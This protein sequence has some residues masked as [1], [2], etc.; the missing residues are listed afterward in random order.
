MPVTS[1]GA[2]TILLAEDDLAVRQLA[3][4]I[5]AV[6]GFTVLTASNGDETMEVA[7]AHPG[8]INLLVTDVIMPGTGGRVRSERLA[9]ARPHIPVLF[10]SDYADEAVVRHRLLEKKVDFRHKPFSADA[11]ASHVREVFDQG[12]RE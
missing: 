3:K 6:R 12:R 5:L 9:V 11:L 4:R 8:V 7:A 2:E 10:P 1:G